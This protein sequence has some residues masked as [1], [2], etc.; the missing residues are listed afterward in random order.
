M[1]KIRAAS[2]PEDSAFE[3]RGLQVLG[4]TVDYTYFVLSSDQGAS[5]EDAIQRY[6]RTG[7][8][9]SFFNQIDDIEPYGP[10]DRTGPGIDELALNFTG[11]NVVDV[12]VWPSG[13]HREAERR[14][15]IIE[16]IVAENDGQVLLRSVSARRSYLR[17]QITAA[18]LSDLLNTSVVELVRRPPVPFLDFR[19]WRNIDISSVSRV[20]QASEVI[21]VLDDSPESSHPLLT[22]L[23]L[24][25]PI[26]RVSG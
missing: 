26:P 12:T 3:G 14:A 6:V 5:L 1:F 17:I 4:E 2:R 15:S 25:D 13:T 21:G 7:E 10:A 22:G 16:E 11:T 18:G 23:V 24:S 20:E 19:D 9:R 8:L